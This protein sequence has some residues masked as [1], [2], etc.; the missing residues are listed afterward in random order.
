MNISGKVQIE[1]FG[2]EVF[3]LDT[4]QFP[5]PWNL[6]Q[7][8]DLDYKNNRLYTFRSVEGELLSFALFGITAGDDVAHLYKILTREQLRGTAVSMDFFSS[9]VRGLRSD[10]YKS[11]YLEVEVNNKRAIRFYEKMG[12]KGLRLSKSFYSFGE[13]ALIMTIML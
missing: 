10:G 2:R 6:S 7:W 3:E 11:I 1:Y 8:N 4:E 5:Q 12:L 13:D 9:L